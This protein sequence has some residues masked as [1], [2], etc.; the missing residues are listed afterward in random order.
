MLRTC[1]PGVSILGMMAPA[2]ALAL[3]PGTPDGAARTTTRVE[4]RP[5]HADAGL[6]LSLPV[7]MAAGLSKGLAAGATWGRAFAVGGR[8]SWST[9]TEYTH[10]HEV[11]QSDLRLRATGTAEL[12]IGTGFLGFRLSPGA[13]LIHE[14]RKRVQGE[15]LGLTGDAL[16]RSAWKWVPGAEL[17]AVTRI[18]LVGNWG[19]SLGIGPSFHWALG[20]PAWGGVGNLGIA[21]L[22]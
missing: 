6:F 1:L 4:A 2:P 11:T 7:A 21:W 12:A 22:P 15:R 17:E 5:V 13:T 16:E 14:T 19:M 9:A 18:K 10:S 20:E 3:E 8:T